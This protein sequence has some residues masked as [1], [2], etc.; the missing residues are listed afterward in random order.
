MSANEMGNRESKSIWGNLASRQNYNPLFV[1]DQRVN[2]NCNGNEIPLLRCTLMGFERNHRIKIPSNNISSRRFYSLNTLDSY[3]N[4][5]NSNLDPWFI[6]GFVDAEGAFMVRV[7]KNSK[8]KTGWTVVA[9]FSIVLHKKDLAVLEDI[10]TCFGGVGSIKKNSSDT[11]SYRI[12]SCEQIY[13][14]VLPFFNKYPLI[15]QK[16]GDYLLF[17][18]V[19]EMMCL[20]EHLTEEGL[21]KIISRKA[22]MNKG[23]SEELTESFPNVHFISRPLVENKVIPHP[24][25]LAGFTSGDGCFKAIVAKSSSVKVGYQV[26]L[27]FQITQHARDEKLIESLIIYFG[28]GYIEKDPRGPWLNFTVKNLSDIWEKIIPF[29][30]QHPIIGIKS[31][32]FN[33]WYKIAELMQNKSHLTK[34]GLEKI[35]SIKLNMNKGRTEK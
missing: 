5:E 18:D 8:Y 34:E 4:N 9:L 1:K 25:W 15:T 27:V 19:V 6:S 7:R 10:K 23:L 26:S 35:K 12:E 32:D 21:I 2:S 17:K 24:N 22:S 20:K 3:L 13:K 28:C 14:Y 11:L 31:S 33:D 30:N 29:F 16:L